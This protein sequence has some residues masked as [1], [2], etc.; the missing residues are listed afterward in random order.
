MLAT[1][2]AACLLTEGIAWEKDFDAAFAKAKERNVPVLVC[3]NMDTE[4]ASESTL[5][6]YK[7]P[8]L[9]D[10]SRD[11]VCLIASAAKHGDEAAPCPRFEGVTCGEHQKMEIK[12]SEAFV[13]TEAVISPQHVLVSPDRKVLMR[14]A[15][16]VGKSELMKMLR[17]AEKSVLS[18]KYAGA[19][20]EEKQIAELLKSAKDRN[21]VTRKP[22]I[23]EL[24]KLE[25]LAARDALLELLDSKNMTETR[26]DAIDALATKGNYDALDKIAA[27]LSDTQAQVARHAVVA[28]EKIGLPAAVAPL[29]KLWKKKPI[30]M[31]A[32]EIP[33]A[34]TACAPNDAE[35]LSLVKKACKSADSHIELN[36]IYALRTL[37]TDA[38][39]LK[40]L[41]SKIED[42]SGRVRGLGS[43][44]IGVKRERSLEAKLAAQLA[45]ENDLDVKSC[46]SLAL[47]NLKL[48]DGA[49]APPSLL[50][51]VGKFLNDEI[52]RS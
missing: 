35:V 40:I 21:A 41:E 32:G 51:A 16:Y 34:L 49:K 6:I 14:R 27:Q 20:G 12:A 5:A 13:G 9:V 30:G 28:L 25:H 8:E 18:G 22:A 17:M 43:W 44:V 4:S 15:Y 33:R 7:E 2:L 26:T 29:L 10:R 31:I 39:V 19:E 46:M 38:E 50:D 1:V 47:D 23:A 37:P 36:S 3:F 42:K 52:P 45:K 48:E 11:F 24:G